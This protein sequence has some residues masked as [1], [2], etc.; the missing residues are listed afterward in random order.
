MKKKL[1]WLLAVVCFSQV[2]FAQLQT[3]ETTAVAN[4][5]AGKVR[6]Y[7]H[8]SIYT[9]KG[10]PYAQAK[11]FEAPQK[12]KP[13]QGVRSS[14]TYGPV[15]PLENPTATVQ[16][17]SEFVF[18]HDW[19]YTNENCMVLNVWTP[20]INDGKKRPVLFWIHGGGFAAGS[21]QELPSYD[22]ENLAKTG[23]V[24]VV[25]INHRLNI[26]G[27]LDLSAY[28]DK[29]KHSANNS[30]VDMRVALE[31]VKTNI[32]GFG[33]DPN[34][35]TIFGQSGGGAKVNALMAMPSA[36]GLFH[37]AINQSGAFR[38]AMLEKTATQ[39]ITAEVLKALNLQPN[40]VDSLQTI[41]YAQLVNAGRTA[42]KITA[43]KM[44]AEGKTI[45]GFG[46]SWG[47]SVDGEDLPYQVSSKEA[48]EL[49]KD[50]PL[51]I[52]T[53]KN[54]FMPS[55][56]SGMSNA[57]ME[58]VTEYIKKQR[59]DKADA[60]LAAVKKA[61]PDDAKPTDLMDVDATF[62]PGAVAQANQKS[63]LHAAPV[64]M[65]LFTWQSP[66][67][68]GKYKAM[69]CMELPF[70]FN[71]IARCEEMTGGTKEAY[72]LA[73]KMSKA[74][75]QFARTGNPNHKGLPAWPAY[76]STNTA[77]MHFNNKCEVKP[78]LDKE[79]FSLTTP[80]M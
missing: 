23:D 37:K 42:L 62:R 79:L 20:G 15:A 34:N 14:M 45:P 1:S 8:N 64:Y 54:E 71:N 17:E 18:H 31:W 12:P 27:F 68:D 66:V 69:H 49:S 58:K 19:G 21:S 25:S 38:T 59:G 75:V 53:V 43:D 67:M 51:L 72:A 6:G 41:P 35:V 56:F 5:D 50:V 30:I 80:A 61:Y 63:A 4:T 48:Y 55:L 74:W 16:D 32:A 73:D 40:Q 57:P 26:L 7:I 9:Y 11:R 44:K 47:P 2:T 52:G 10:I 3:G 22:G 24:V 46:L 70:V 76:N 60:F 65:Y 28:G 33:G 39:A 13:W 78:Q 77:T 36:K 29:Y